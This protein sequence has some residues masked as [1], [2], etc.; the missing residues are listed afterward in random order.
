M[1]SQRP[2]QEREVWVECSAIG[3]LNVLLRPVEEGLRCE[4]DNHCPSK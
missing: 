2:E 1:H 4:D 3:R